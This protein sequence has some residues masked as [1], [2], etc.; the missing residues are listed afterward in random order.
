MRYT[1]PMSEVK[2]YILQDG[3]NYTIY[4][5][6]PFRNIESEFEKFVA[7]FRKNAECSDCFSLFVAFIK[8]IA[9]IGALERDLDKMDDSVVVL[10]RTSSKFTFIACDF[11]N[12]FMLY[13]GGMKTLR[14][15]EDD[16]FLNGFWMT[17]Y[18]F[19]N[20]LCDRVP[21]AIYYILTESTID[22]YI[23]LSYEMH[24]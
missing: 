18:K 23:F 16:M 13:N 3:E 10:P 6:Q 22:D 19:K 7:K 15:Y 24:I 14:G 2:L 11:Q 8:Y 1:L 17:L 5:L 21:T 9:E 20:Y 12:I 4:I